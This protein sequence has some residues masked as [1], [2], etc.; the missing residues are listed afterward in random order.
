[1]ITQ[2]QKSKGLKMKK[3]RNFTLIELLVVIAIIAILVSMLLPALNQA[4]ERAKAIA[5]INNLKQ[6]SLSLTMYGDDYGYLPAVWGIYTFSDGTKLSNSRALWG[7]VLHD[8]SYISGFKSMS[9]PSAV[10]YR[11]PASTAKNDLCWEAY[12]MNMFLKAG[13]SFDYQHKVGT[14]ARRGSSFSPSNTILVADSLTYSGGKLKQYGWLFD[15]APAT[16]TTGLSTIALR[17]GGGGGMTNAAMLDG[18]V[19]A[20]GRSDLS[21]SYHFSGGRDVHGTPINF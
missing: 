19:S 13:G 12:G 6:T 14:I 10:F 8:L 4:R 20:L 17:H 16:T 1:L 11:D 7:D 5:C 3:S 2:L 15:Y 18:H 9:C 21:G